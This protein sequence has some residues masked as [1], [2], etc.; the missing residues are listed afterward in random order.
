MQRLYF[1]SREEISL[2]DTSNT[3]EWKFYH[4]IKRILGQARLNSLSHIYRSIPN[5]D[6]LT[7][8]PP[9]SYLSIVSEPDITISEI[10]KNEPN[11]GSDDDDNVKTESTMDD[12]VHDNDDP[13]LNTS[14]VQN[15]DRK[16]QPNNNPFK[17]L[18]KIRSDIIDSSSSILDTLDAP[19]ESESDNHS[20]ISTHAKNVSHSFNYFQYGL[21]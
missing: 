18:L 15:N 5:Y 17:P 8:Q 1:C 3:S 2:E 7:I 9:T 21:K 14:V 13:E 20:S 10:V 11:T 16:I 4:P 12:S 19:Y 6:S